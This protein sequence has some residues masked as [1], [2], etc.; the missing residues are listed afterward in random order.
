MT[1]APGLTAD[2]LRLAG[3]GRDGYMDAVA[4]LYGL[5]AVARPRVFPVAVAWKAQDAK[6]AK[7][8]LC[9]ASPGWQSPDN[10]WLPGVPVHARATHFGA[11]PADFG[12]LVID[13][14][15]GQLADLVTIIE[16]AGVPYVV[17]PTSAGSHVLIKWDAER[18]GIAKNANW[19]AGQAAGQVRGGKG[20]ATL[21]TPAPWCEALDRLALSDKA[22]ALLE[23]LKR[24]PL[25]PGQRHDD[26]NAR[27]Y[28]QP[29]TRDETVLWLLK[30][31][32][33]RQDAVKCADD[34]A[35]DGKRDGNTVDGGHVV[36]RTTGM[37]LDTG[38]P[39]SVAHHMPVVAKC[40][41]ETGQWWQFGGTGY[42][43]VLDTDIL[44]EIEGF[45]ADLW[46]AGQIDARD[47]RKL[48]NSQRRVLDALSRR[49]DVMCSIDDWNRDDDLV[50]LADGRILNMASGEVLA[51][52]PSIMVSAQLAAT[53]PNDPQAGAP[54][55]TAW[56]ADKL[57]DEQVR[58][59]VLAFLRYSLTGDCRTHRLA[60]VLHSKTA[61]TGKSTLGELWVKIMGGYGR[62]LGKTDFGD[63]GN[64]DK[65]WLGQ[66]IG[67]RFVY[68]DDLGAVKL[69]DEFRTAASGGVLTFIPKYANRPVTFA[70]HAHIMWTANQLPDVPPSDTGTLDRLGVV[71]WSERPVDDDGTGVDGNIVD[72]LFAERDAILALVLKATWNLGQLPDAM[73]VARAAHAEA[74]DALS[75]R[76][77][78]A[79]CVICAGAEVEANA[80]LAQLKASHQVPDNT[81][82]R[83]LTRQCRQHPA[84]DVDNRGGG[85]HGRARR[86]VIIGVTLADDSVTA[87]AELDHG[88]MID[89]PD[90][91]PF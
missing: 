86:T 64:P 43:E 34:A 55:F 67:K 52:D 8:P 76:F 49:R 65:A 27:V 33:S 62:T 89:D 17:A 9:G 82:V 73:E 61:R 13:E 87:P 44:C 77:E 29:G 58:S 40:A 74:Q 32:Y 56:L 85:G 59:A 14:D 26:A 78:D 36:M 18:W 57:P 2:G 21:W 20:W 42:V 66:L 50:G 75:Q 11:V 39:V 1:I 46:Q 37:P 84:Y 81:T 4:S 10:T 60:L 51:P 63:I 25:P 70:S 38:S 24:A 79:G 6:Y 47:R 5:A 3:V 35:R 68:L 91:M 22:P 31:G 28:H 72:R 15:N 54:V 41:K 69:R 80:L 16:A 12:L 7:T 23:A 19:T 45:T 48:D 88:G 30:S 90:R 83:W 53:L 71:P